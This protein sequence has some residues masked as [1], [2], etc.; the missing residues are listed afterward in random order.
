MKRSTKVFVSSL[1]SFCMIVLNLPMTALS[2]RADGDEPEIHYLLEDFE[3]GQGGIG[4]HLLDVTDPGQPVE[5][6]SQDYLAPGTITVKCNGTESITSTT[7]Q[8]ES[9]TL[10]SVDETTAEDTYDLTHYAKIIDIRVLGENDTLELGLTDTYFVHFSSPINVSVEFSGDQSACLGSENLGTEEAPW[11]EGETFIERAPT[12]INVDTI[13]YRF[14]NITINGVSQELQSVIGGRNSYSTASIE[15]A[16]GAYNVEVDGEPIVT[17]DIRWHNCD[18][19]ERQ[20]DYVQ[21]EEWVEFG[22]VYIDKIYDNADDMNDIT[23]QF[24]L[25]NN[26]GVDSEG[27][28]DIHV[29]EGNVIDFVFVP[30]Y[31]YQLQAVQ[32]NGFPLNPQTEEMNHYRYTMPEN[33]VHFNAVFV[34]IPGQVLS[35]DS[36]VESGLLQLPDNSMGG[37]TGR[38]TVSGLDDNTID[39]YNIPDGYAVEE[40]FDID[41]TNI[42]HMAN[43]GEEY[44][45]T[46]SIHDPNGQTT[47][48]LT[49]NDDFEVDEGQKVQVFHQIGDDDV[50]LVNTSYDPDT[51]M[52]TFNTTGFSDFIVTTTTNDVED[53]TVPDGFYDQTM[54][55][56]PWGENNQDDP[57]QPGEQHPVYQIAAEGSGFALRR[58]YD[59]DNTVDPTEFDLRVGDLI[60]DDAEIIFDRSVNG[61]AVNFVIDGRDSFIY[62]G[63]GNVFAS[64]FWMQFDGITLPTEEGG[65]VIVNLIRV[66]PPQDENPHFFIGQDGNSYGLGG[67]YWN[68]N[69]ELV[70]EP[71]EAGESIPDH[72]EICLSDAF[73][74]SDITIKIAVDGTV[75]DELSSDNMDRAFVPDHWLRYDG[76]TEDNNGITVNFTPIWVIQ[77]AGQT[78]FELTVVDEDGDPMIPNYAPDDFEYPFVTDFGFDEHGEPYTLTFEEMPYMAI[79]RPHNAVFTMLL[80][81]DYEFIPYGDNEILYPADDDCGFAF[82]WYEGMPYIDADCIE[83]LAFDIDGLSEEQAQEYAITIQEFDVTDLSEEEF[84]QFSAMAATGN[85]TDSMPLLGLEI[86]LY[87]DGNEESIHDPGFTVH[88]TLTLADPLDL[89]D[90]QAVFIIHM[91]EDDSYEIIEAT[92]DA[93]ELTLTF[94]TSSFS[95]FVSCRGTKVESTGGNTTNNTTNTTTNTTTTTPTTAATPAATENKTDTKAEETTATPTPTAAPASG[96]AST[97]EKAVSA[98]ATIGIILILSAAAVAVYNKRSSVFGNDE[99]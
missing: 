98:T 22:W 58:G 93:D 41:L 48:A 51:N 27:Y 69:D 92:Y 54:P 60:E 50:E 82:I 81:E 38:I 80:D 13:D 99:D 34:Q 57:N 43:R 65:P 25:G 23:D 83:D 9:N 7:I 21:E 32:A 6:H 87:K 71:F 59:P 76:V 88:I 66:A 73:R 19:A 24:N 8:K 77:I 39:S 42:Y 17:W 18:A 15:S 95:P 37:G 44:W 4:Y 97:G 94:D 45:E 10:I 53:A 16:D 40:G 36:S 61:T 96:T 28:G 52:I 55:D 75:V 90:G 74:D 5:L 26:G 79:V 1:I 29:M 20:G 62:P 56:D 33:N 12:T 31:G 68:E 35:E 11:Y 63:D 46:D 49:L 3:D 30:M 91:L 67:E 84:E 86:N 47:I 85:Y 89:E 78:G 14:T 70:F 2:I 72:A 64:G